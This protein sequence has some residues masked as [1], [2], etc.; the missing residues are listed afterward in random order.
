MRLHAALFLC[1]LT[2]G[3][4]AGS[5]VSHEEGEV[6]SALRYDEVD[7]ARLAAQ[8]DALARRHGLPR[9]ARPV[10][11]QVPSGLGAVAPDLRPAAERAAGEAAGAINAMNRSLARRRCP[12]A[13]AP[14]GPQ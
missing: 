3:C 8:R 14:G 7:C 10:F 11:T 6:Q 9:D 12:G 13:P 4:G 1:L 2:A 5:L